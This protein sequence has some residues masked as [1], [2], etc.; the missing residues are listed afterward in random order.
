MICN[1]LISAVQQSNSYIYI[2]MYPNIYILF[3][4]IFHYGLFQDIEYSSLCYTVEPCFSILYIG[5]AKTFIWEGTKNPTEL[6]GH[7]NIIVYTC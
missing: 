6:F 3:H 5:L 4:I 7:P 1:V 2:Y